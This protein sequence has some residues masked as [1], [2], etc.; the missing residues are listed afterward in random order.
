MTAGFHLRGS[1]SGSGRGMR[2]RGGFGRTAVEPSRRPPERRI[3]TAPN[4]AFRSQ[5]ELKG[6]HAALPYI[7]V[8]AFIEK[9]RGEGEPTITDLAFEFLILTAARTNEVIE[10]KWT[11]ID[12]EQGAWTVPASR[13]KAGREHRVPLAPRSIELLSSTAADWLDIKTQLFCHLAT[14]SPAPATCW[15]QD[16]STRAR[17]MVGRR[18]LQTR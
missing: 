15:L 6:H 1:P 14:L 13:M 18:S 5:S 8:P 16:R 7:E 4:S 12:L 17:W 11:E 9:A 10:A 2:R 3:F